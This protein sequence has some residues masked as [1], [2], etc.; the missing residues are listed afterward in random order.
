MRLFTSTF[1]PAEPVS[2]LAL[3][4]VVCLGTVDLA[5]VKASQNSANSVEAKN[6]LFSSW[7]TGVALLP[8]PGVLPVASPTATLTT[9]TATT[10]ASAKGAPGYLTTSYATSLGLPV[11]SPRPGP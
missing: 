2:V 4:V 10:T 3:L 11:L 9:S 1:A 6:L 5:T 7:P 8:V